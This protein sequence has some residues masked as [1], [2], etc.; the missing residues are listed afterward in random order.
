MLSNLKEVTDYLRKYHKFIIT[1]NIL[2]YDIQI[3]NPKLVRI[4]IEFVKNNDKEKHYVANILINYNDYIL[5]MREKKIK[6]ILERCS[7]IKRM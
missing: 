5:H 1:N 3:I 4:R 7:E 2:G 6:K